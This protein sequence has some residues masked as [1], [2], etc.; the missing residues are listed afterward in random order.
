MSMDTSAMSDIHDMKRDLLDLRRAIW[1]QREMFSAL[2]RSEM[3]S[4]ASE[5]KIYLRDCYQPVDDV[6]FVIRRDRR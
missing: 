6:C 3:G 1:P 2:I 4:I 5:T